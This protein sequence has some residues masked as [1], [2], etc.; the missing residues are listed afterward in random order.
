MLL[1]KLPRSN[2]V[3]NVTQSIKRLIIASESKIDIPREYAKASIPIKKSFC[4]NLIK[5]AENTISKKL[6]QKLNIESII[7]KVE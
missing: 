1:L 4:G 7:S 2:S 3:E 6:S 5:I